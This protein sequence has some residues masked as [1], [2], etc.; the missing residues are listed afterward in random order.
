LSKCKLESQEATRPLQCQE[1]MLSK[2][3]LYSIHQPAKRIQMAGSEEPAKVGEGTNG[4]LWIGP[5]LHRLLKNTSVALRPGSL[6]AYVSLSLPISPR[7][8]GQPAFIRGGR[9]RLRDLR[10][11]NMPPG[12]GTASKLHQTATA[13]PSLSY[14]PSCLSL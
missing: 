8:G 14:F 11:G 6:C 9:G 13:S 10:A 5:P 4:G 1:L 3:I 12:A 2:E 7:E